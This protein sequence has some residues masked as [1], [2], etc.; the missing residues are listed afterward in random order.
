MNPVSHRIC[1]PGNLPRPHTCVLTVP[2]AITTSKRTLS[3]RTTG[4]HASPPPSPY[5]S[6]LRLLTFQPAGNIEHIH[7]HMPLEHVVNP[8]ERFYFALQ[9]GVATT[10]SVAP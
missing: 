2:A 3:S 6:R 1:R 7:C 4:H 5:L 9:I 8:V 10:S